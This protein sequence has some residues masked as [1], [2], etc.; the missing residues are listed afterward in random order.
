[1]TTDAVSQKKNY[2]EL[3]VLILKM[4]EHKIHYLKHVTIQCA[5]SYYS[6]SVACLFYMTAKINKKLIITGKTNELIKLYCIASCNYYCEWQLGYINLPAT[7]HEPIK[8]I[9]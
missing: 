6:L 1:M 4:Q 3:A 5:I 8:D 2:L 9:Y 7:G